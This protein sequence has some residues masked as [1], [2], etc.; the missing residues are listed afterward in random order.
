MFSIVR[1]TLPARSLRSFAAQLLFRR[2]SGKN[3]PGRKRCSRPGL[4]RRQRSAS[5]TQRMD[6]PGARRR[7]AAG[8]ALRYVS[9]SQYHVVQCL[10]CGAVGIVMKNSGFEIKYYMN[11]NSSTSGTFYVQKYG[12]NN[13]SSAGTANGS[14]ITSPNFAIPQ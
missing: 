7:Q 4:Y 6:Q 3:R 13:A 11:S 14:P 1:R 5:P 8:F 2:P 9:F 12:Q 10:R